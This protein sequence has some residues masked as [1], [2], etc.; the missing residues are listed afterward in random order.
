MIFNGGVYK[1]KVTRE[2]YY[3]NN[4]PSSHPSGNICLLTDNNGTITSE[5]LPE[6]FGDDTYYDVLSY[7]LEND[8]LRSNV[9]VNNDYITVTDSNAETFDLVANVNTY[10]SSSDGNGGTIGTHIDFI[11]K[12]LYNDYSA[13]RTTDTTNGSSTYPNPFMNSETITA[14]L[15]TRAS[16]LPEGLRSHIVN[17]RCQAPTRGTS[18]SS[19]SD[20]GSTWVDLGSNSGGLWLPFR[21]EI[22][23]QPEG[24]YEGYFIQYPSLNGTSIGQ[25]V[26]YRNGSAGFWWT[27]SASSGNSDAFVDVDS[28]GPYDYDTAYYPLGVPLCFRFK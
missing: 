12:T 19:S 22:W 4:T 25:R 11:S 5:V 10:Y 17:K 8:E 23:G 1:E 13:M 7:Y 16:R 14:F 28:D 24:S 20:N 3:I 15:T 2:S 6:P 9:I 21:K 27:A 26:K 18:T